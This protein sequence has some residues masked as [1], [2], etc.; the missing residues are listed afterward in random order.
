MTKIQHQRNMGSEELSGFHLQFAPW[1]H[2]P[3]KS[4]TQNPANITTTFATQEQPWLKR[5][6][7]KKKQ[8]EKKKDGMEEGLQ[9]I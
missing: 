9:W 8:A 1:H 4:I 7:K 6:W 2:A 3:R 5:S